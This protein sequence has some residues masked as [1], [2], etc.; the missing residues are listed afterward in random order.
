VAA[1][2]EPVWAKKLARSAVVPVVATPSGLH[3]GTSTGHV[4]TLDR[5]TGDV[6]W[7]LAAGAGSV[8]GM[9]HSGSQLIVTLDSGRVVS[10]DLKRKAPSW[11]F[12]S[13]VPFLCPPIV[14]GGLIYLP[15]ATGRI[16]FLEMME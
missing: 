4:V 2:F 16:Q 8:A 5:Q 9:L 1:T 15:G 3:V 12:Q 14:L 13:S 6:T 11:E 7:E 10:I